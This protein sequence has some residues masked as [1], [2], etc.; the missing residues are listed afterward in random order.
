MKRNIESA[1]LQAILSRVA[2]TPMHKGPPFLKLCGSLSLRVNESEK[3]GL[4]FFL[5]MDNRTGS[6][7]SLVPLPLFD[8]LKPPNYFLYFVPSRQVWIY[9]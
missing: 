6:S 2:V 9:F 3:D 5:G 8:K 7:K 1:S 4:F